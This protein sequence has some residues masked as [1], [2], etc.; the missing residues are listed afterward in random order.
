MKPFDYY[1]VST[2]AQAVALLAKYQEKAAILAGGSDLLG[3][4]K[5]G[6]EGAGRILKRR[7]R[8]V[9]KLAYALAARGVL[10]GDD[11]T[12]YLAADFPQ[13]IDV[14]RSYQA[15]RE[16]TGHM[17]RRDAISRADLARE[18]ASR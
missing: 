12:P 8:A 7:W 16:Q 4:M 1:R 11:L 3:M 5:D 13:H 2:V 14:V 17:W 9:L 18:G 15:W 10:A 6:I